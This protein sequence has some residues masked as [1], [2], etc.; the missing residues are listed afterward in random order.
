MRR[1]HRQARKFHDARTIGAVGDV[2]RSPL[3]LL[4][5]TEASDVVEWLGA[6]CHMNVLLNELAL[7]VPGD[8]T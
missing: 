2:P 3:A 1:R 8:G 6:R 4:L 7:W 5:R